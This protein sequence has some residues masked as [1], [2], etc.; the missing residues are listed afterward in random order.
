[1]CDDWWQTG[2]GKRQQHPMPIDS[3][4]RKFRNFNGKLWKK[5]NESKQMSMHK[6]WLN[7]NEV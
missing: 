6:L 2:G 7:E 3:F 5:P 1:M 4:V